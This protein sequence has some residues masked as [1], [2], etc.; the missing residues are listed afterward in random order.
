MSIQQLGDYIIVQHGGDQVV[1]L[2]GI[3][4]ALMSLQV[5][6]NVSFWQRLCK[7]SRF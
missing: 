5:C 1:M 7:E 2:N 6:H 3:Y 4:E